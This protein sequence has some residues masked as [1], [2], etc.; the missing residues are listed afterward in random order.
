MKSNSQSLWTTAGKDQGEGEGR[1]IGGSR[2]GK[3]H[4]PS[5]TEGWSALE[6]RMTTHTVALWIILKSMV[7]LFE[8]EVR[9]NVVSL[10]N[11]TKEKMIKLLCSALKNTV[12]SYIMF[13]QN[14]HE[15]QND[16]WMK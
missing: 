3:G 2:D 1:E 12:L 9:N 16:A 4:P 7:K 6:R 15:T 8:F 5:H 11:F 10:E 14:K 13:A